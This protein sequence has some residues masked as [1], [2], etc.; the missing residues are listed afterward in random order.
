MIEFDPT[1]IGKKDGAYFI[2]HS[3]L[4]DKTEQIL[5]DYAPK[6]LQ[7][8]QAI[9]YEDFIINY[10]GANEMSFAHLYS[11][12][13]QTLGCTVFNR[14]AI[15]VF[16]KERQC[17]TKL[18]MPEKSIILDNSVVDGK[19]KAQEIITALHEA[20]HLWMH[21]GFYMQHDGQLY[22]D[23]RKGIVC[24][25]KDDIF[26][27]KYNC[28]LA[29]AHHRREW[30]ATAFAVKLAMP[31][32]SIKVA[33]AEILTKYGVN[34]TLIIDECE[35]T[36]MLFQHTLPEELRNIYG[37]SKESIRYRLKELGLC[38]MKADYEE[39]HAQISF[40]DI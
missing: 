13:G 20:G 3:F 32:S 27:A 35:E 26:S 22:F 6:L 28:K 17:R 11:E 10:L 40:F 38:M 1:G 37:V 25:R 31:K 24:C 9:D 4:D 2:S 8:P 18:E 23:E 36:D 14:Q 34:G 39:S 19:R 7:E 16:D 12:Q 5:N 15:D 29:D 30:Q 21:K 33:T